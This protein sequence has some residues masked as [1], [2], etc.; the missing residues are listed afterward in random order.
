[1]CS[2]NSRPWLV[3][4]D[5]HL[6]A[7]PPETVSA[8]HDFVWNA[9]ANSAGLVINGDLFDVWYSYRYFVP[10]QHVRTLTVLADAVAAGLRIVFVSGN[11]DAI[12]W[13]SGVLSD[14]V[15]LEVFPGPV[16]LRLGP[17][18]AL[19]AHGDGVRRGWSSPARLGAWRAYRR[20]HTLLRNPTF[21]WLAKHVLGPDTV[22]G[23]MTRYSRTPVWVARHARGESTGPK[24]S[25]PYI[26]RWSRDLL[27]A[28]RSLNLVLAGHSHLPARV[29]VAPG[30]YYVN[31]GDWVSHRTYV[32]LPP[33]SNA[34]EVREWPS[35]GLLEW[36]AV[37]DGT[38]RTLAPQRVRTVVGVGRSGGEVPGVL[39]PGCSV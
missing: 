25:A 29:E 11:R 13:D 5:V 14:D 7:V 26:E 27:V 2:D 39:R 36:D 34:P 3:V 21:V 4:S 28:D 20:R 10:R 15:G 33:D 31:S 22:A 35:S 8:F 18:S 1:M 38:A 6:G 12:E 16:R 24:R 17:W 19:V 30:R 9:A 37:D 32:V 23:L